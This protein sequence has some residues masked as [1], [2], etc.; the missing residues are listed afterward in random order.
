MF[1]KLYVIYGI[2]A[3]LMLVLVGTAM[4]AFWRHGG[5]VV[6]AQA[7]S[8]LLWLVDVAPVVVGLLGW[9]VGRRQ[10]EVAA[11]VEA[12][13]AAFTRTADELSSAATALFQSVSAFSAM[14]ADTAA[15]V[16]ET[17]QTMGSLS[18]TAVRAALTAET[19]IGLAQKSARS[20]QDGLRAVEHSAGGMIRLAEEVKA[21]AASTEALSV[22][23]R[24]VY[25]V[26]A[27]LS[28]MAERSQSLAAQARS[29]AERAGPAGDGIGRVALALKEHA[30]ESRRAADRFKSLLGEV[31]RTMAAALTAMK[32]GREQ[33]AAG[34]Q[35]ASGTGQTIRSLANVIH[36]SSEAA[37]Q[38]ATVAQQQDRGI[39]E[40]LKAMNAIFLAVQE[41]VSQTA[42]VAAEARHLSDVAAGLKSQLEQ[43]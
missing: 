14:T 5:S 17:T 35:A 25:G 34:A 11:L 6:A 41:A 27:V 43:G 19:V 26:N 10:D 9:L 22:K 15:S 29:E 2:V 40:T 36:E 33:A 37:R 32:T 23:M 18:Q 31:E 21:W 39:E 16:Q 30:A 12:R 7:E 38:I 24:D 42:R 28:E 20:S 1:A 3:G 4:E 8:P 13:A